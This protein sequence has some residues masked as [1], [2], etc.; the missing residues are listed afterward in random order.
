MSNHPLNDTTVY[1]D[2]VVLHYNDGGTQTIHRPIASL[3]G[4]WAG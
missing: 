1:D 3:A 2:D 4:K